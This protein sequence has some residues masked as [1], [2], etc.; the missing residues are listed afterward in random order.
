MGVC[1]I[2]VLG[3]FFVRREFASLEL[4]IAAYMLLPARIDTL[5]IGALLALLAREPQGLNSWRRT[6]WLVAATSGTALAVIAAWRQGLWT[7]DWVVY[8]IGYTLL[9][10]F[11]GSLLTL[12]V[13]ASPGS[14]LAQVFS[15]RTLRFFGRYSYGLY[16]FHHPIVIL[17]GSSMFTVADMPVIWGSQLPA[18]AVYSALIGGLSCAAAL[19]SWH[20]LEFPFLKLKENFPYARK[21]SFAAVS[22]D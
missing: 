13:T 22:R 12:A 15:S 1:G 20:L 21:A 2:C 18:F 19:A 16:V 8:T 5:A 14:N 9:A 7:Q 11:L 10:W 6:A 3:A 17:I 4:P